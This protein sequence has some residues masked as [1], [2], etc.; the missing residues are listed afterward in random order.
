M[1]AAGVIERINGIA[2][3]DLPKVT[4]PKEGLLA[5]SPDQN[6]GALFGRDGTISSEFLMDIYERHPER[7][8]FLKPVRNTLITLAM[9][10]GRDVNPWREEEPGKIFHEK[11]QEDSYR[12]DEIAF[13]KGQEILDRL[14][15]RD[16]PVE[17][18]RGKRFMLYDGSV[19][20][21]PLFLG[22]TARYLL[23]TKSVRLF[24]YLD[25]HIRMGFDWVKNYGDT[26][27]DG[28]IR[29]QAKNRHA[30]LNQG[31]KD[32]SDS[33]EDSFGKRPEEP[34]ALV[35]VQG[36]LFNAYL[37]AAELYR[38]TGD[39]E[40]AKRL[41]ENAGALKTRFNEDFWIPDENTFAHALDSKNRQVMEVVSNSGHLLA[42]GIVDKSKEPLLVGRL[43]M[44]DLLTDYGIRTL[45]SQSPRFS[46]KEPSAYHNGAVWPHDNALISRGMRM[47]GYSLEAQIIEDRIL[48]AQDILATQYGRHDEELFIVD[49]NNNL[50]P[51]AT[52]QHPQGWVVTANLAI[53]TT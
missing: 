7:V 39:V 30:L 34:I 37:R 46:D 31:W 17:G 52:S 19:D 50:K 16:W 15:A 18:E 8:E 47:R 44:P 10:Q 21:T 9:F 27:G 6:F 48:T 40:Y 49:R 29:Y 25:P 24:K 38:Q 43:M 36:Y 14:Q 11:R 1:T 20:S 22:A 35:E 4:H 23:L 2:T 42:S 32:S 33:I 41:Y 3:E 45:S 28:Y 26:H 5:T 51:Y 12:D 13:K 53:T